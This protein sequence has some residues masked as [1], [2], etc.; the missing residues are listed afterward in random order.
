[1]KWQ[2]NLSH[3]V[4]GFELAHSE[5]GT[6]AFAFDGSLE[7]GLLFGLCSQ[8]ALHLLSLKFLLRHFQANGGP[9]KH[10]NHNQSK[11][12]RLVDDQRLTR[13]AQGRT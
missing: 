12:S 7:L 3:S 2:T 10:N 1:M 8:L 13:L 11:H 9:G 5:E 6:H 4:L